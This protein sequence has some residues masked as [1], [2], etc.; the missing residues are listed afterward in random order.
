MKVIRN[1]WLFNFFLI[2]LSVMDVGKE[3]V[4]NVLFLI[5][6]VFGISIKIEM[7]LCLYKL[8]FLLFLILTCIILGEN[9]LKKLKSKTKDQVEPEFERIIRNNNLMNI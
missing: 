3:I 1:L 4:R 6:N 7:V 8:L 2:I 5:D 9:C